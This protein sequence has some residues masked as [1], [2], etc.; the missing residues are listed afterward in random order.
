MKRRILLGKVCIMLALVFTMVF[1][2]PVVSLADTAPEADVY[3]VAEV[4]LDAPVAVGVELEGADP[5]ADEIIEELDE[6][7]GAVL[8]SADEGAWSYPAEARTQVVLDYTKIIRHESWFTRSF[9]VQYDGKSKVAY[10]IEPE[11]FP[12]EKGQQTAVKYDKELL[13]SGV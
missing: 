6:N 2:V 4:D 13:I 11:E 1:S 3:A 12:P 9:S 10:C 8:F 5:K 7:D